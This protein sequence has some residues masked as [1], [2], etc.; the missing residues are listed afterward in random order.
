MP[1]TLAAAAVADLSSSQLTILAT[2]TSPLYTVLDPNKTY[3]VN[4]TGL[5]VANAAA[6]GTIIIATADSLTMTCAEG[7]N[8]CALTTGT[9][10]AVGPGKTQLHYQALSGA[11]I[12]SISASASDFGIH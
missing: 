9:T 8:K 11:P 12:I 3:W 4:H 5:D 2:S 6:T 7:V 10:I 1:S